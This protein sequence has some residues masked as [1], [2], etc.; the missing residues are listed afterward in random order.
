MRKKVP[1]IEEAVVKRFLVVTTV[2]ATVFGGQNA[3]AQA[4]KPSDNCQEGSPRQTV[5]YLDELDMV[6]TDT[7]LPLTLAFRLTASL[8]PGER[9][10][11]V[12]LGTTDGTSKQTWSGC[13]PNGNKD[14]VE[15]LKAQVETSQHINNAVQ[16]VFNSAQRSLK[17]AMVDAQHPPKKQII[18]ALTSDIARFKSSV[19]PTIRAIV[20]SD[21]GENSNLG[22]AY[23]P[24]EMYDN[25]QNTYFTRGVFYFFGI[26]KYMVN[27]GNYNS[28]AIKFWNNV[29]AAM[30]AVVESITPD[31]DVPTVVPKSGRYY[32]VT[33][34]YN[35]GD[36]LPGKMAILAE[37]SGKLIDSWIG[38][39]HL[40][41]TGVQGTI[42]CDNDTCII[43]AIT[44]GG[45]IGYNSREQL[46]VRV[47]PN[48]QLSGTIALDQKT[49]F[50]L[51]GRQMRF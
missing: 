41:G 15:T 26:G 1:Y 38:I 11:I 36:D 30:S 25:K 5:V 42:S 20:Y 48:G 29:M 27:A 12:K 4:N 2:L 33:L 16:D 23:N 31:F 8:M 24:G 6:Q 19:E 37:D 47:S 49:K 22:S 7:V 17:D 51:D 21:L 35:N 43:S 39:S 45:L 50:L 32:D 3:L 13:W 9:L 10:T 46:D 28:N 34:H 40:T 18:K 14:A 44:Q